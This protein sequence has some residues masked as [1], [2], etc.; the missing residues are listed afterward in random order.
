MKEKILKDIGDTVVIPDIYDETKNMVGKISMIT[1]TSKG[2]KYRAT[3]DGNSLSNGK[4]QND[5]WQE[6]IRQ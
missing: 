5:F 1:V 3:F 2:I 4:H 6:N